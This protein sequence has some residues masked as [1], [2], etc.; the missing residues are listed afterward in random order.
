MYTAGNA[1]ACLDEQVSE[2]LSTGR[3]RIPKQSDT[4]HCLGS[5]GTKVE[6]VVAVHL[7]ALL[8]PSDAPFRRII[9]G[10]MI[11]SAHYDP[12]PGSITS[13]GTKAIEGM[14]CSSFTITLRPASDRLLATLCGLFITNANST[15]QVASN[16]HSSQSQL[17]C[18]SKCFAGAGC[19]L[20]RDDFHAAG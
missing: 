7:D 1:T 19:S 12:F 11:Y 8:H 18:L 2:R 20:V 15:L 6:V 16:R 4:S 17:C 9:A 10:R 5:R 13:E 3:H 14:L